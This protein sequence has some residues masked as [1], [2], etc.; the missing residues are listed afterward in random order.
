M[1][2]PAAWLMDEI[3]EEILLR[4]PPDDPARLLDAALVCKRW[5][6]LVTGGGF[7]R[8]F[9]DHHRTPP[10]LGFLG[11]I[12]G[13]NSRGSRFFPT[14]SFRPPRADHTGWYV[15]SSGH[16]RV[17]FSDAPF[18]NNRL[19]K[20]LLVWDP[21]TGERRALPAL[22]WYPRP[23][24]NAVVLCAAGGGCNHLDCHR[25]PFL[26]VFVGNLFSAISA[27]VYSSATGAWSEPA[28]MQEPYGCPSYLCDRRTQAI[29]GNALY[30]RFGIT[31]LLKYDLTSGKVSAISLPA[32][33]SDQHIKLMVMED[34]RLGYATVHE[35][36]L[37]LWS[38]QDGPNGNAT[39][40][41]CRIVELRSL[42]PPCLYPIEA[43]PVVVDIADG[44]GVIFMRI[45]NYGFFSL[46]LKSERIKKLGDGHD[47]DDSVDLIVPFTSFCTPGTDLLISDFQCS[48]LCNQY[49][50]S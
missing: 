4:F 17:L 22:A 41:Q 20:R 28:L 10:L 40:A 42:L 11:H 44:T 47:F 27:T 2:A 34:G 25:R 16:G 6:R 43:A 24:W 30:H 45:H 39:W 14:S 36:R 23:T 46:D 32:E 31:K 13:S 7:R 19:Y 5:C 12:P 50:F 33:C 15:L 1:A 9:R 37:C 49:S 38:M 48:L 3:V 8:R 35:F 29:V 18:A 26:V 21:I